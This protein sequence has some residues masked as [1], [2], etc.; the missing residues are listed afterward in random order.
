MRERGDAG[1]ADDEEV[2]VPQSSQD[3]LSE[4]EKQIILQ[5]VEGKSNKEV[6]EALFISVNTVMTHRRNISRK[7]QIHSTAG[8]TIYAIVNGL[9]KLEDL[10]L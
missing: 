4:R 9:V 10:K 1:K 8:L 5:L 6:A 7:L 3:G 2:A